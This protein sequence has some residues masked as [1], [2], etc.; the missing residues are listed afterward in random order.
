V[1]YNLSS[2]NPTINDMETVLSKRRT[3]PLDNRAV[4]ESVRNHGGIL[5][6][7]EYGLAADDIA[8]PEL[9]NAWRQLEDRYATLRPMLTVIG[10]VLKPARR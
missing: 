5:G 4:A 3:T 1:T 9:A 7:L 10:R 2:R 6:A 8:D